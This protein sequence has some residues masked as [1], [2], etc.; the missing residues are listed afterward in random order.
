M[1]PGVR[2]RMGASDDL[3]GI[4]AVAAS[5]GRLPADFAERIDAR[6]TDADWRVLVAERTN[7]P[8]V[9]GWAMVGPWTGLVD[10]PDGRYV[11]A[12]TVTP[13]ARRSGIGGRLLGDL[14]VVAGGTVFSVVNARNRA[15]LDLHRRQGFVELGRAARFAGID[16]DGGS[17][18]LLRRDQGGPA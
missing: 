4:V 7:A 11:S 14:V 2:V 5:R 17:G 8:G 13:E 12:L 3:A 18:V 9:I 6:M 15:S 1:D 16:F 10:A